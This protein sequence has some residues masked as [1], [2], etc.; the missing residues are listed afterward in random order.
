VSQANARDKNGNAVKT[1][2]NSDRATL[3]TSEYGNV[4]RA[5]TGGSQYTIGPFDRGKLRGD[6]A[7]VG[8]P[9]LANENGP[10]DFN[11]E[12]GDS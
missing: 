7:A 9:A 4:K 12:T 3:A 8:T 5:N 11:A 1:V 10:S 2:R 6:G